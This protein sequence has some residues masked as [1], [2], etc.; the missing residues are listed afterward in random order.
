[1]SNIAPK[2]PRP[3]FNNVEID[4]D[5]EKAILDLGNPTRQQLIFLISVELNKNDVEKN[6]DL[7]LAQ[8]LRD[9]QNS[10]Y[11]NIFNIVE[12]QTKEIEELDKE[13][14]QQS[15][16]PKDI[17]SLLKII[18]QSSNQSLS[19]SSSYKYEIKH[20]RYYYNIL[21]KRIFP[22]LDPLTSG[23]ILREWDTLLRAYTDDPDYFINEMKKQQLQ[24]SELVPFN[25]ENL[26]DKDLEKLGDEARKSAGTYLGKEISDKKSS[27]SPLS[28]WEY[29]LRSTYAEASHNIKEESYV[30]AVILN[31]A[32][33]KGKT[34]EDILYEPA[35]FESV[36]GPK[37]T[38]EKYQVNPESNFNQDITK[39][40]KQLQMLYKAAIYLTS[41]KIDLF[42]DDNLAQ[43][44]YEA[45]SKELINF[46]SN[47][48][49]AYK[50]RTGPPGGLSYLAQLKQAKG[51]IIV[52]N[53]VFAPKV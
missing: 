3:K 40:K 8:K 30:M 28:E 52:G 2:D 4:I 15:N 10:R 49:E 51:S 29:L 11:K 27:S 12:L 48:K 16:K 24:E 26:N 17:E 7:R 45:P 53:T 33:I 50:G 38:I 19:Y 39:D 31:R 42:K 18:K 5:T 13:I 21:K 32:R 44:A 35:Q 20:N 25:F 36:T 43:T 47:I 6:D 14:S 41:N 46:T 23:S 34:I 1:M 9:V 22:F 37:G